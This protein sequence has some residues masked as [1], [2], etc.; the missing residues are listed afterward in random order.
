MIQF[1]KIKYKNIL[2]VGNQFIEV[3]LNSHR[4]TMLRG[5]NGQGKCLS[6]NTKIRLKNKKTGEI[7]ETSICDFFDNLK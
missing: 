1:N 4:T 6:E 3:D 2:S 7:I 5:T